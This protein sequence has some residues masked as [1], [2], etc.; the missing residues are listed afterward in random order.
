MQV[1]TGGL[2]S[3]CLILMVVSFFQMHHR[4]DACTIEANLGVLLMGPFKNKR[5]VGFR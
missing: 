4:H 5:G 1:F 3:Y 2:S